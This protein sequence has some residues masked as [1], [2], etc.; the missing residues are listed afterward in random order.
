MCGKTKNKI[1]GNFELLA[2]YFYI[3]IILDYSLF[4]DDKN[5]QLSDESFF[6]IRENSVKL[7]SHCDQ[8]YFHF[9]L[10]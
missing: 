9:N 4:H 2:P 8:H 5:N 3:S 10:F 6:I 7:S 1:C